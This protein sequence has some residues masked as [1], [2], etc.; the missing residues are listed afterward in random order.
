M[1]G[2][3]LYVYHKN[4][5]DHIGTHSSFAIR[6]DR[7]PFPQCYDSMAKVW[8]IHPLERFNVSLSPPFCW[9]T[10]R[11]LVECTSSPVLHTF[12]C[13]SSATPIAITVRYHTEGGPYKVEKNRRCWQ[14]PHA[15]CYPHVPFIMHLALP[16]TPCIPWR[17]L[18]PC[19]ETSVQNSLQQ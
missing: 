2:H 10:P 16:A 14:I 8:S 3:P 1:R 12:G 5:L 6:P 17:L 15:A 19:A 18:G 13:L 7:L 11:H 4:L 9:A